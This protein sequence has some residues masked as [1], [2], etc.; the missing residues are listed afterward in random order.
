MALSAGIVKFT[1]VSDQDSLIA[2]INTKQPKGTYLQIDSND[3]IALPS[4][5][6]TQGGTFIDA[7]STEMSYLE[8]VQTYIQD[9]LNSKQPTGNYALE[10]DLN[11]YLPLS[12][13]QLTGALTINNQTPVLLDTNSNITLG[14]DI[15]LSGN[16]MF[17]G[18]TP[19][20]IGYLH[21]AKGNIQDQ[22][23]ALDTDTTTL[24]EDV[25]GLGTTLV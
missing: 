16:H 21:N 6:V 9:Q 25:M 10:T 2:L 17:S 19:T 3:L 5:V 11:K 14:S 18:A 8:G 1:Q 4:N 15:T 7:T 24:N 13:G 20:E 12:G 22:L 23:D